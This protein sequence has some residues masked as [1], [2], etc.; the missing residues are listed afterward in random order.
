MWHGYV[1]HKQ[2]LRTILFDSGAEQSFINHKFRQLLTQKSELLKDKYLVA[3]SN[4]HLE[5]TQEI[6][7]N[8]TLTLNDHIFHVNLMPMTIG[9]FDIII[10]MDWLEPHHA[11]VMCVREGG[12]TKSP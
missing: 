8:C 9:S 2:H 7:N 12:A 5:S 3:M 11:D 1:P 4:G 10:G 6:L